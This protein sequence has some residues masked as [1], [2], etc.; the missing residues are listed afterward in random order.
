MSSWHDHENV[1]SIVY[2][3]YS[4]Q[5]GGHAIASVLFGD[6]NPS[7]KLPFTIANKVSDY[8]QGALFNGSV[9]Y[10]PKV[11]FD[12]GVFLDYKF[13]DQK[14]ITPLYE[15]GFGSSYST[16]ELSGLAVA[17][18]AT[19]NP[20][21][22]RET[23]EKFFV[24]DKNSSSLYDVAY[25]ATASVKNTGDVAGAEVAQVRPSSRP[26]RRAPLVPH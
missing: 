6:V 15:F 16:F 24:D 4:G 14:N 20:A 11:V 7:G 22:V 13:F 3:Y 9:S 25:T 26:P 10:Q 1:S 8:D 2:A 21:P 5:E 23:N 17:A 12:E 18:N 19:A